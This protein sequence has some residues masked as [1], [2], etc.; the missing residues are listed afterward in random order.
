MLN[1]SFST[2]PA[3]PTKSVSVPTGKLSAGDIASHKQM[4]KPTTPRSNHYL[5]LYSALFAQN[6]NVLPFAGDKSVAVSFIK[7]GFLAYHPDTNEITPATDLSR[8]AT[9]YARAS[10]SVSDAGEI[11]VATDYATT[12][13]TPK[14]APTAAIAESSDNAEA[15]PAKAKK[16]KAK[17]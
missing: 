3:N 9:S 15:K 17:A 1:Y 6:N 4:L 10:V 14:P 8:L 16:A 5:H 11:I 12:T 13:C 7:S 2:I